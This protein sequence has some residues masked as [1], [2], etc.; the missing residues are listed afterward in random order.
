MNSGAPTSQQTNAH[1][2]SVGNLPS[3]APLINMEPVAQQTSWD[4]RAFM[5]SRHLPS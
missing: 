5:D 2:H 4:N 1:G 3:N